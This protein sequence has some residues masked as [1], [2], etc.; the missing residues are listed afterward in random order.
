VDPYVQW[1]GV[2][3][4]IGLLWLIWQLRDILLLVFAA[5]VLAVALD[6]LSQI[7][8]KYGFRRGP[9]LAMTA[10][11]LVVGAIM[12]ALIV[13]PPLIEQLNGLYL[14]IQQ[15]LQENPEEFANWITRVQAS[16]QNILPIQLQVTDPDGNTLSAEEQLR[17]IWPQLQPT[18]SDFWRQAQGLIS[19]SLTNLVSLFLVIILT[20]LLVLDPVAYSKVFIQIFP[21]FYRPRIAFIL[22]QCE[23]TL[24][25]WLVGI[26]LTSVMVT[27]LSAVG[28]LILRVPYVLANAVLAGML[29]FIPNI[30]PTLSVVAPMAAALTVSAWKALFVLILYILIQQLESTVLTPVVMSRQVSLLPGLTL[31]A[32][33]VFATFFGVLGLFL[34]VP[35]AAVLQVWIRE[36]LIRDILDSWTTPR[37]LARGIIPKAHPL[38]PGAYS[39][40]SASHHSGNEVNNGDPLGQGPETPEDESQAANEPSKEA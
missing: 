5:I 24:R 25:S 32:Q 18:L 6:T 35:L 29:N 3:L 39:P 4:L 19:S 13:V 14:D 20:I 9:A 21:A 40:Q 12:V 26:L 15:G 31:M 34:A 16:I 28:L 37:A 8:Q 1:I 10:L 36:A 23:V 38:S 33:V 2:G 11:T 22:Q 27:L 17:S 30:G 7:P